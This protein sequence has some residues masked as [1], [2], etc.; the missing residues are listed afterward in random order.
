[1]EK[2][3]MLRTQVGSESNDILFG[4]EGAYGYDGNDILYGRE[5]NDYIAAR[6]GNDI[7]N[8]GEGNDRLYG[9]NGNDVLVGGEG[10]DYLNGGS[11]SDTYIHNL[12]DGNDIIE[13]YDISEGKIHDRLIFGEGIAPEDISVK[14]SGYNL[15]LKNKR[16]GETVTI[17]RALYSSDYYLENIEFADGTIWNKDILQEKV[18]I[19]IGKVY[20]S[21]SDEILYG[22]EK[23][24]LISAWSGDDI[25][26]GEEGNDKLYGGI[27]NDW[28]DGGIGDDKLYGNDGDD[29]LVGGAGD[30]YLEGGIGNDTYI[31]NIGDGNDTIYDYDSTTGN[32][33]TLQIGTEAKNL[34]FSKSGNNLLI[35]IL[36][37]QDSV[38]IKDWY[39][40]NNYHVETIRTNDGCTLAHTQVE[41]L[42]QSMASF[43]RTSGMTWAEGVH[44]GNEK[45][46]DITSQMWIKQVG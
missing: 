13:N 29:I 43:E 1:M 34:L 41:L 15:I 4:R 3:E 19:Q 11:G 46:T 45:V 28:L 21:G 16:N 27:G 5:G 37:T 9:E 20:D 35:S 8:G 25:L 42:I 10:N 17:Y 12:G 7:L 30:D 2:Q 32:N 31:F 26:Y 38:T 44:T 36:D 22:D 23:S 24:D 14:K 18:R 6:E 33:D 39:G 40:G